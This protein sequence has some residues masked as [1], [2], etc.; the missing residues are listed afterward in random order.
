MGY[1]DVHQRNLMQ[2]INKLIPSFDFFEVVT[3]VLDMS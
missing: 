3:C 1:T 2:G